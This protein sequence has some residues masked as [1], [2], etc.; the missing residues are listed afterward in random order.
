[1]KINGIQIEYLEMKNNGPF[2]TFS[3]N[4]K[5]EEKVLKLITQEE[6]IIEDPNIQIYEKM[7]YFK[8]NILY[9]EIGGKLIE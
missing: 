3:F 6:I 1:M 5:D 8:N 9:F 7:F 2:I 4:Q